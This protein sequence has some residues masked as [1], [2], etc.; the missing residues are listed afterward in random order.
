MNGCFVNVSNT[1]NLLVKID[2]FCDYVPFVSSATNGVDLF[3]KYVLFPLMQKSTVQTSHYY[4]H[5][6]QKSLARCALLL[7]PIFGNLVIGIYDFTK[8]KES[9]KKSIPMDVVEQNKTPSEVLPSVTQQ[10]DSSQ[11][12]LPP[13]AEVSPPPQNK[14]TTPKTEFIAL[15]EN[16]DPSNPALVPPVEFTPS[17]KSEDLSELNPPKVLV[18]PPYS[19]D[20]EEFA[21]EMMERIFSYLPP[22]EL[23]ELGCSPSELLPKDPSKVLPSV[24]ISKIFSYL[25]LHELGTNCSVSKRWKT[26]GSTPSL[27]KTVL[28]REWAFSSKNW[29]QWDA[30]LVK[31]VDLVKEHLSLPEN[32]VEELRRSYDA[33]AGES[34]RKTHVLVRMPKGLTVNK[35]GE[36][37]KKYFPKNTNGYRSILPEIVD[38][39]GNKPTVE[40]VWLLMTK[41]LLPRSRDK[42]YNRQK[43]IVI[44]LAKIA[45]VPYQVPST[46][47]AATCILAEHSRSGEYLLSNNT[48]TS[49]QE[50]VYDHPIVVGNF[51][52]FGFEL[53]NNGSEDDEDIGMAAVRK[54]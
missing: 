43:D 54:F 48:Y 37:A 13:Q 26:L 27:W 28:Y 33:F 40:S 36:L 38:Q 2:H 20:P 18:A 44:R 29:A 39:L 8:R 41:D 12:V 31:D 1:T 42:N 50:N 24:M 9:N 51:T 15:S 22:S 11:L 45:Q 16:Q 21:R 49:C 6:D 30:D 14:D 25:N 7:I 53:S 5:L 17:P 23:N 52:K 34:I 46:L 4:K 3:Q 32:I 47:E 10:K 19:G 35:L